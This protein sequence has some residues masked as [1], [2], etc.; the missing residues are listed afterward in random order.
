MNY[1][2]Y[3]IWI[4]FRNWMRYNFYIF[5]GGELR[6]IYNC[7]MNNCLGQNN[8]IIHTLVLTICVY[9]QMSMGLHMLYEIKLVFEFCISLC[10]LRLYKINVIFSSTKII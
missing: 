7:V 5:F 1:A 6:K 4:D 9:I 2:N 10:H 3:V 8:T